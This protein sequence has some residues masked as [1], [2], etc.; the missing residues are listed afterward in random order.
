MLVLSVFAIQPLVQGWQPGQAADSARR[1]DRASDALIKAVARVRQCNPCVALAG[2]W[3][4]P[5][6]RDHAAGSSHGWSAHDPPASAGEPR[7]HSQ[8][9]GPFNAMDSVSPV[10]FHSGR[11]QAAAPAVPDT[12]VACTAACHS[13]RP[14]RMPCSQRVTRSRMLK[15]SCAMLC[16]ST[17][18]PSGRFRSAA[19]T[20]QAHT[21]GCTTW[22]CHVHLRPPQSQQSSSDKLSNALWHVL[23]L[24]CLQRELEL[25]AEALRIPGSK[26]LGPVAK[27]G[28]QLGAA[29]HAAADSRAVCQAHPHTASKTCHVE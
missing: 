10:P 19:D 6:M 13:L 18:S 24:S 3:A 21:D 22:M 7:P 14:L 4:P 12:G 23:C 11:Q 28:R 9:L 5:E 17:T 26:S 1:C 8:P 25:I 20:W 16:P 29:S 2:A 27:V 15:P